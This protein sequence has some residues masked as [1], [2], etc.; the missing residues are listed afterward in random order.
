M[1]DGPTGIPRQGNRPDTG[2]AGIDLPCYDDPGLSEGNRRNGGSYS[3][4][5]FNMPAVGA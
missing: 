1:S 3:Q 2:E 5:E 4:C